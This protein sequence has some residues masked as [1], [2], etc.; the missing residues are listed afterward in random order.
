MSNVEKVTTLIGEFLYLEFDEV[1]RINYIDSKTIALT[2]E[3]GKRYALK[4]GELK[5][6]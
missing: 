5:K 3:N 6:Q 4:V 1:N 2:M